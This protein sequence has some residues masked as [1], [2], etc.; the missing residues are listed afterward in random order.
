M[1]VALIVNWITFHYER[2]HML[3]QA[4]GMLH[5]DLL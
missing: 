1:L 5:F 2:K 3:P 4:T